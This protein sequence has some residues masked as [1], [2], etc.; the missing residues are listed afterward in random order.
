MLEII[1]TVKCLG[2]ISEDRRQTIELEKVAVMS[3]DYC[4]GEMR[5]I[6]FLTPEEIKKIQAALESL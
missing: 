5:S 1:A 6:L 2:P 4:E 3:G